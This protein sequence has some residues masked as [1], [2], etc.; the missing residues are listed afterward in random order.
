MRNFRSSLT[1]RNR[2]DSN[3]CSP[4]CRLNRV[5]IVALAGI[6]SAGSFDA[7]SSNPGEIT[8]DQ[9]LTEGNETTVENI[10]DGIPVEIPEAE[11]DST[12]VVRRNEGSLPKV[13]VTPV[14]IDRDK[15]QQ[16]PLHYYDKHGNPL[17]EPVRFLAELDTVT[18][19]VKP[20]PKYPLYCGVSVG[21]NFFDGIMMAFGQRRENFD[22]EA[23]VSLWNW[24]FPT[25]EVG[26]ANANARPDEGRSHFKIQAA[27]FARLGFDYNFLYKSNPDYRV[28]AGFRAG[29][30]A[31]SYNITDI[32]PGS[33]YYISGVP[34]TIY[35]VRGSAWFGQIV[36]GI[37]IRVSGRVRM[38][39]SFRYGFKFKETLDLPEDYSYKGIDNPEDFYS[40]W[41]IPG[42]GTST[43]IT[44]TFTIGVD[45]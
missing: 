16:T 38:G 12:S 32:K 9:I 10:I 44:G 5:A 14:D 34:T 1:G 2:V 21:V 7:T 4:E 17:P 24:I 39:W 27:P 25:I 11:S 18:E 37:S 15:P 35:G 23:S 28:Y 22:V 6:L 30:S 40:P 33:R 20:G 3:P 13:R 41:F 31:F 8:S 19:R 29:W 26:V 45:L 43:P 36:A 42:L